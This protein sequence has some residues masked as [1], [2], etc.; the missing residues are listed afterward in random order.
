MSTLAFRNV[1]ASPKDR[2]STWPQEG[3]QAALERGGMSEWRRLA[4]AIRK[5]P[6][7]SVARQVEEA[8]AYSR[9]YG[10]A[11]MMEKVIE[12]ARK[13]AE[14]TEREAVAEE[15]RELIGE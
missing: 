13:A 11:S 14:T 15:V 6:W 10:V 12:R 9:P 5:Q 2:V 3:I 4:R 1:R 8:L 7:G